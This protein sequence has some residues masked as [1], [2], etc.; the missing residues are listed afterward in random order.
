MKI[1]SWTEHGGLLS[2]KPGQENDDPNTNGN[3]IE[4]DY[5]TTKKANDVSKFQWIA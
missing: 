3:S 5:Y 2:I 1:G 4:W